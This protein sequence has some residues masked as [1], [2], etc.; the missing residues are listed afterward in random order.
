MLRTFDKYLAHV[1]LNEAQRSQKH[2][3]LL[4]AFVD[5]D[6]DDL[7]ILFLQLSSRKKYTNKI[8]AAGQSQI[9]TTLFISF[10]MLMSIGMKFKRKAGKLLN[11]SGMNGYGVSR[12][13]CTMKLLKSTSKP[14]LIAL[15]RI[16]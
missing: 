13:L 2:Q 3:R 8:A 6:L 9:L 5:V 1:H 16:I 11:T 10:V 7:T 14:N 12:L 4:I 15:K